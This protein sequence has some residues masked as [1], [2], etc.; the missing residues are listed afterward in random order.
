MRRSPQEAGKCWFGI[1]RNPRSLPLYLV[2]EGCGPFGALTL[3]KGSGSE[4]SGSR[5]SPQPSVGIGER[6][7]QEKGEVRDICEHSVICMGAT[8]GI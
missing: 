3:E 7:R 2:L 4:G 8:K 5:K 6:W 1:W